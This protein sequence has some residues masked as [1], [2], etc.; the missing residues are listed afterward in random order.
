MKVFFKIFIL[1]L[2]FFS[3]S[4]L[5][6]EVKFTASTRMIVEVGK[7]FQLTYTLNAQ[8]T[9]FRGPA[10]NDF[11]VLSGPNTSS[12][13]SIQV[14]NRKMTQSVT[15]TF[16]YYLKAIKE[17]TFTISP[18]SVKAGNKY[19]RSNTLTIKVVK[20]GTNTNVS[21]QSIA[22]QKRQ[23]VQPQTRS[24]TKDVF[25]K[26]TANKTNPFQGEQV[27]VTYKIYTKV[28][29]AQISIDKLSSFPGFWSKN[30]LNDNERLKQSTE[31]INGEEYITAN[32]RKI[33]LFPQKTAKLEIDPMELECIAQIRKQKTRRT[34]S[35][36][37]FDSFFD[38]PFFNRSYQNVEKSLKSNPLTINVKPLPLKNKPANFSGAVGNF[39]F[40][41]SI[42]RTELKTNEAITLKY[43]I[44]GKG[45]IE[46]INKLNVSFPPDFEV[47]D[48]KITNRIKTSPLGV[49]GSCTFEYL[50][51]PRNPGEFNTK[52]VYFSYFDINTKQYITKSTPDY[53][54]K[55][56]KGSGTLAN[57]SYI[58]VNQEDIKYIGSDI[59]HIKSNILNLQKINVYFFGSTAFY[60]LMIIPVVFFI[61]LIIIWKN[62]TKKRNNISL[63]KNKKATK[64]ARKNLRKAHAFLKSGSKEEFYIEISQALWGYLS[65]KFNIPRAE[66][67][68]DSVNDALL[69]KKVN[70]EIIRQFIDTLNNCEFARFAPGDSSS[71]MDEIYREALEIIS[72]IERELR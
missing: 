29:I 49:S 53:T 56:E 68:M 19:Y 33:T 11:L 40:K 26:A 38:D 67:S 6:D 39:T 34:T 10:L 22:G 66:L 16:T 48:P 27:I 61:L 72:K 30:L 41:S 17:G 12:S 60:L 20:S 65:D 18:A 71:T 9:N 24:E 15:N 37:F 4:V 28:P 46:L 3:K 8:G 55:V 23:Q 62:Q 25:L 42:D 35:D 2:I 32:I 52:P 13:S 21:Q 1:V 69:K 50:L 44:S 51:I 57:I 5:A 14:I 43:T 31:I 7:Q 63:M 58:G 47:Y 64:V 59:R 45:N 70:K 36:P 54:I